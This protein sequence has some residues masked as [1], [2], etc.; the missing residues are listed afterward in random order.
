MQ[1]Q[2][3]RI[4]LP[5][6]VAIL[7]S[8][9]TQRVIAKRARISETRLSWFVCLRETPSESERNALAKALGR[10]VSDIFPETVE[11]AAS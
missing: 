6:K 8:G 10:D 3:K 9:Y 1:S 2:K 5:L 7:E 11:Q 4:H